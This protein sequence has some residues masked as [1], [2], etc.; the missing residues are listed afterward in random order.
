MLDQRRIGLPPLPGLTNKV[1]LDSTMARNSMTTTKTI[2]AMDTTTTAATVRTMAGNIKRLDMAV[3][4]LQIRATRCKINMV[5]TNQD[6]EGQC[7]REAVAEGRY[8]DSPRETKCEAPRT[9]RE[10]DFRRGP[11]EDM[12]TDR[13]DEEGDLYNTR[14]DLIRTQT[15]S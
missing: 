15:V 8:K 13:Q 4:R 6:E 7:H 11:A 12:E 3:V 10:E 5:P 1:L 9:R 14:E 2:T